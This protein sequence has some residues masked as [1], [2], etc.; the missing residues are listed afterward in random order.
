MAF[1]SYFLERTIERPGAVA[2]AGAFSFL[3][4]R[5]NGAKGPR[6][7]DRQVRRSLGSAARS[8]VEHVDPVERGFVLDYV[9]PGTEVLVEHGRVTEHHTGIPQAR[10]IPPAATQQKSDT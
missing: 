7:I 9:P 4:L 1:L 5:A 2:N 8:R 3:P 10:D 6:R